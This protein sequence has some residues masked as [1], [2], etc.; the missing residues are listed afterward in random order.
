[1]KILFKGMRA[2]FAG[3]FILSSFFATAQ[4]D[5][6]AI[7]MEKNAFC[8]GPMYSYSSWK[9]YWEGTLKRENLNIGKVTTQMYSV[10]GNYGIKIG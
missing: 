4:T 10:M 7:M 9:D 1:M 2:S 8:V 3:F 5:M 6:D